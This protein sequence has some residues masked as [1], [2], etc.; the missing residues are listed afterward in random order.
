MSDLYPVKPEI[1]EKAH[2][3][4]MAEYERLYR[5]SLDNPE[6][7]W[8]EQ[9][10]ALGW[11]HPWQNVFDADYDE[12]DFAWFS[13]GRLNASF[14]C[15]DR[16]LGREGRPDRD[17]L[18]PGRGRGLSAHLLSRAEAQ[19]LPRGQRAAGARRS[20]RGPG[21]HLHGHDA[22]AGLHH[23]RLRPDRRRPL[24]GVRRVQLRGPPGPHRR[25]PLPRRGHRQ[26]GPPRRQADPPQEDRGPGDRGHVAGGDGPGGAADRGRGADGAGARPLARRGV[27]PAAVHLQQRVDGRRGPPLHPLHLREHR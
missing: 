25:R 16:H 14:N 15:V 7:F 20:S 21:V 24:G 22:G 2:V 3:G 19:R 4:S 26:R 13:G 27:R 18:G 9:A 12:V 5:L 23:A 11:F 6:W 1:A 10:K 17:H 8:A